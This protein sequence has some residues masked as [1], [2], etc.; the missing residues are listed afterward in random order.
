M[1]QPPKII[2]HWLTQ[3]RAHRIVWLLEELELPYEL[4]IYHRTKAYR[5]PPELRAL[6]PLGRSPVLEVINDGKSKL[7]VESGHIIQYLVENFDYKKKFAVENADDKEEIEFILHFTEASL[8]SG[9]VAILVNNVAKGKA[10]WGLQFLAGAITGSINK[11]FYE[12][13]LSEN[14]NFLESKIKQQHELGRKYFVGDKL[15]EADI[16]LIFPIYSNLFADAQRSDKIFQKPIAELF[17]HLHK[18][19]QEITKEP[20]LLKANEVIES[21]D[22]SAKL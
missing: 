1:S 14:L 17:P 15:S 6:H 18:W 20:K 10:P 16:I 12:P 22:Q 9:L 13:Q 2:L 5:S 3:S 8:Q 21:L 7:I 4:K 11:G 19:T